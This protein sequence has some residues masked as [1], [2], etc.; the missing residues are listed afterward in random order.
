[1]GAPGSLG[2]RRPMGHEDTREVTQM[3]TRDDRDPFIAGIEPEDLPTQASELGHAP[4]AHSTTIV[5][6]EQT[7][8]T[9][10]ALSAGAS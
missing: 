9:S 8:T 5:D 1:M 2:C 10:P 7:K 6:S 3:P 4:A